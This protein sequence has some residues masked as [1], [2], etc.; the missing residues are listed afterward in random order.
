MKAECHSQ[1]ELEPCCAKFIN[2]NARVYSLKNHQKNATIAS[3]LGN[4]SAGA[5]MLSASRSTKRLIRSCCYSSMAQY[6]GDVRMTNTEQS[7]QT[8]W[9]QLQ[10]TG[11]AVSWKL[12]TC[13][14]NLAG[15]SSNLTVN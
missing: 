2:Q 12:I 15:Q 13:F 14:F 4:Q 1:S 10:L 5:L 6:A 9:L 7:V 11:H 3:C 8:C